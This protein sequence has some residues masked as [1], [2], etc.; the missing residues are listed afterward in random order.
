MIFELMDCGDLREEEKKT[1]ND[2]DWIVSEQIHI[3]IH[4]MSFTI[5]FVCE[6]VCVYFDRFYT[7]TQST[8]DFVNRF[9]TLTSTKWL[10]RYILISQRM[11]YLPTSLSRSRLSAHTQTEIDESEKYHSIFYSISSFCVCWLMDEHRQFNQNVDSGRHKSKIYKN[12][13]K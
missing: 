4:A 10:N 1:V 8:I 2:C 5:P 9:D 7:C 12:K 6:C 3:Q 11:V 13:I